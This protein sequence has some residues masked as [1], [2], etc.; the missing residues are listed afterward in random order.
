MKLPLLPGLIFAALLVAAAF[1]DPGPG[2]AP[3]PSTVGA[4]ITGVGTG[5]A[6]AAADPC[7]YNV[8]TPFTFSITSATQTSLVAASA[9]Q[10]I[11][12]CSLHYI[13]GS[14]ANTVNFYDVANA[15]ACS[16]T[17][18]DAVIGANSN[19]ATN[20]LAYSAGGGMT[21]GNGEGE[22]YVTPTANSTLCVVT[23]SAGPLSGAGMYVLAP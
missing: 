6:I 7:V 10:K 20:G 18:T 9:A 3:A 13:A 1:A 5:S 2:P 17:S 12:I 19:A 15:G 8:K 23:S 14:V 4:V 11:Y 22:I 21:Q 16:A